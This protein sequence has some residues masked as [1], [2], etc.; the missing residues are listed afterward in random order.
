MAKKTEQDGKIKKAWAGRFRDSMAASAE[1]FSSSIHYDV[2]LYKQDIVQSVAYA[3]ALFK[4]QILSE[5]EYKKIVKALEDILKGIE[6]GKI[7]LRPELE[8]LHMNIEALL[9]E[10]VGSMGK[11]LHSG[12]SRNDQVATDLRMY[13]KY[14]VTEAVML[15]RKV[16]T[17]LLDLAEANIKVIVPG[18]THMQR[19]QPVLLSHHLMAYYEMLERDKIRFLKVGE[20]ADVLVLGS[21]ALAGTN[22]NI[23]RE[24]LAK[25]LGFSKVSRNSMDAVSDRDFLLDFL[26]A[27]SVLMM[28][29][30][31]SILAISFIVASCPSTNR[32]SRIKMPMELM[33]SIM[34]LA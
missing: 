16:Q 30:F 18:Y 4:V 7:N 9:I 22:F 6:K 31:S 8:D 2:R 11:K 19:A 21:G 20:G 24:M 12:R 32:E 33:A 25:E 17:I 5:A 23:D 14:E 29:R 34:L 3:K 15:I 26:Q 13:V 1:K 10:K 27:S 28:L